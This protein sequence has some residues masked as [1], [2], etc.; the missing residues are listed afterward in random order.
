M[1]VSLYEINI[2]IIFCKYMRHQ[3]IIKIY[4]SFTFKARE[5]EICIKIVV[6]SLGILPETMLRAEKISHGRNGAPSLVEGKY[7]SHCYN[8]GNKEG[9]NS[10]GDQLDER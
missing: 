4:F 10:H 7:Q 1:Q 3:S 9:D 8:G 6:C 2:M 5:L